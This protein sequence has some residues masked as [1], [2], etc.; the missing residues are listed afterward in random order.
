MEAKNEFYEE[1]TE[2]VLDIEKENEKLYHQL[3]KDLNV[4]NKEDK[5]SKKESDMV[6]AFKAYSKLENKLQSKDIQ[7]QPQSHKS[8]YNRINELQK[9]LNIVSNEIKDYVQIYGNNSL[10]KEES[11]FND[12]LKDLE[13]YSS[14]LE[15]IINSDLYKNSICGKIHIITDKNLLKNEIK[16]NLDNYTNTTGRLLEL[17]SQEKEDF[18]I[19]SNVMTT[20]THEMFINKNLLDN[21]KNTELSNNIDNEILEIEKELTKIE[22]IVGKKKLNKNEEITMTRMLKQLIKTINDKKFQILKE[23]ALTDLNQVLD[24]LLKIKEESIDI[25]EYSMKI[26]ELYAIYEVYENYDEIM[27]YIK[28]RLMAI[29]DMH[30]KSTDYNADLEFLKKLIE[31]NEKQFDILGKRYNEAFEELGKMEN[32]LIELKNIDKYFAPLFIE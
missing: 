30:E 28:K 22:N 31:D 29:S 21:N 17:L 16:I 5:P 4:Q 12:I 11:N 23:K 19:E 8:L 2:E 26:K 1:E 14:K 15:N 13:L 24:E 20:T 18:M 6:K 9:E 32:I 25:S 7:I 27:K 10:L 3:L